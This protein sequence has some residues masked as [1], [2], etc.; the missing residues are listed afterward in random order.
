MNMVTETKN[1]ILAYIKDK[2]AVAPKD[3]LY[4]LDIKYRAI[5]KQL[6]DLVENGELIKMGSKPRVYYKLAQTARPSLKPSALTMATTEVLSKNYFLITPQGQIKEG[7]EGFSYWCEKNGLDVNK[8]AT[9]YQSVLKK[10]EQYRKNGL[11]DGMP[12][13]KQTFK[14]VFLDE[15]YYLDFYSMERFGKTKLGWLLLYAKQTQNLDLMKKINKI[16]EKP[17]KCFI[18]SK[19]ISA[20]AFI[21]PTINRSVQ[22]QKELEKMLKLGVPKLNLVKISNQIAIPQK[23]LN[24]L[25]DRIENA[26][27]TIMVDDKNV[28]ENILLIDDAVGSGATLNETAKQIRDKRLC[29]G[30]IFA[31]ALTGSFKGFDVIS[32]I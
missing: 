13:F 29:P 7:V 18:S 20:I 1:K 31:I 22:L 15:I 21:P 10:Y 27:N 19:R 16:I 25:E 2:G 24:K 6:A 12:K 26:S 11:I 30:K 17:I 14:K 8:T 23:S 28:Y 32:E 9:E 3:L 4:V 5:L